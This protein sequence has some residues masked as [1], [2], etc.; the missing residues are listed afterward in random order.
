MLWRVF[1][2]EGMLEL[3]DGFLAGTSALVKAVHIELGKG[4]GTCRMKL[5]IFLCLK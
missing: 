1:G 2:E 3:K 4:R 5:L